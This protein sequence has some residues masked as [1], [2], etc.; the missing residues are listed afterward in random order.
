MQIIR[1]VFQMMRALLPSIYFN[2]TNLPF[3]QAIKLP[4]L[5][6]R[7]RFLSNKGEVHIDSDAISFGMIR[8]GF[9]T[10][11]LFPNTGLSL[12]NEGIIT[13][14][15]KCTI[16]NDSYIICGKKGHLFFGNNFYATGNFRMVSEVSIIIG[17]DVLVGW[18]C[19]FLDTD[20][21]PLYDI[22]NK[23]FKNAYG[24]VTIGN[25][26]WFSSFCMLLHSV[27]T[28][29][30]CVFGSRSIITHNGRF[31]SNCLY[32]GTPAKC[33][34]KNVR[35]DVVNRSLSYS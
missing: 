27:E 7:T 20:F 34:C 13:F 31:E 8:L 16:G 26:N 23:N 17:D 14:K 4:I 1:R 25:N 28:S 24:K 30:N 6:Y 10:T 2:F 35:L 21:H 19:V 33:V 18:G 12:R 22:T 9:K 29:E 11:D 32:A 15:G 3:R 5:T